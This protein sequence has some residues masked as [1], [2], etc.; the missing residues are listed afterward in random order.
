MLNPG[1]K[2]CVK[3]KQHE[4]LRADRLNTERARERLL[5]LSLSLFGLTLSDAIHLSQRCLF[6]FFVIEAPI[7][8]TRVC[9]NPATATT[10][11]LSLY[12]LSCVLSRVEFSQS[13]PKEK[14]WASHAHA[15]ASSTFSWLNNYSSLSSSSSAAAVDIA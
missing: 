6:P 4:Q 10:G 8:C 14:K 13:R 9:G 11:A 7:S 15:T 12:L 1:G 5:S 2:L 3:G